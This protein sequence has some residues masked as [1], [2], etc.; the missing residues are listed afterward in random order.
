MPDIDYPGQTKMLAQK[1]NSN[2]QAIQEQYINKQKKKKKNTKNIYIHC[3]H[4]KIDSHSKT[5]LV[6]YYSLPKVILKKTAAVQTQ[7]SVICFV[8]C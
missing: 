7:T 4:T 8:V 5:Y 3:T 6:N 2:S 1:F